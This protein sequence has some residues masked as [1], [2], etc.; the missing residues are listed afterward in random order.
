[1]LELRFTAEAP[2]RMGRPPITVRWVGVDKG[3][4]CPNSAVG[5]AAKYYIIGLDRPAWEAYPCEGPSV[6][7]EDAG[8]GQ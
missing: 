4:R 7:A 8:A 1:M 5:D 2:W 3:D 6:R